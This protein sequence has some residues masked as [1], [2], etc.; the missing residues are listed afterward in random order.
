MFF[1]PFV[2]P[3]SCT[4]NRTAAFAYWAPH[5]WNQF[6]VLSR[7]SALSNVLDVRSNF[8]VLNARQEGGGQFTLLCFFLMIELNQ[9]RQGLT[10][11]ILLNG[12]RFEFQCH[13]CCT[14]S[15]PSS[16]KENISEWN[17]SWRKTSEYDTNGLENLNRSG[18]WVIMIWTAIMEDKCI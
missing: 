16:Y 5:L 17:D 7:L 4:K 15:A 11:N 9:Q 1:S 12:Q 2:L 8:L 6:P 14:S 18:S 10:I 13:A 3:L